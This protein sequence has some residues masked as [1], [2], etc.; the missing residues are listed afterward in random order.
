MQNPERARINGVL[1]LFIGNKRP[2]FYSDKYHMC[3]LTKYMYV[4]IIYQY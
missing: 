4:Y 2:D 3:M 1:K